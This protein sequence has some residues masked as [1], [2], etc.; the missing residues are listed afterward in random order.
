MPGV[1]IAITIIA[2]VYQGLCQS[3]VQTPGS[4]DKARIHT[5]GAST[6]WQEKH[7]T[8]LICEVGKATSRPAAPFLCGIDVSGRG[9][10]MVQMSGHKGGGHE[11]SSCQVND[12]LLAPRPLGL[13]VRPQDQSTIH[14]PQQPAGKTWQS[15]ICWATRY[16]Q[17]SENSGCAARP[18]KFRAFPWYPGL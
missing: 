17:G 2:T 13:T 9:H 12:P 8:G 16:E 6:S 11:Q 15:G 4:C 18:W 14:K 3:P 10:A 7:Q 1:N 5:Q